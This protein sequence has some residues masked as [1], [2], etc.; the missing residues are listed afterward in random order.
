METSIKCPYRF[1]EVLEVAEDIEIDV[2]KI[3][4]Y[5]AEIVVPVIEDGTISL[6]IL[7]KAPTSIMESGKGAQLLAEVL[8]LSE[9]IMVSY[10]TVN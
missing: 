2:P 1:T 9:K 4:F 7:T 5:L 8:K 3:W 10:H 6:D